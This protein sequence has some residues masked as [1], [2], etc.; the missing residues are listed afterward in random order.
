MTVTSARWAVQCAD[1][2]TPAL[3][4]REAAERL[5]TQVEE[6]GNCMFPHEVVKVQQ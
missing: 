6:A 4:S 2:T 3:A 5:L 1:Y